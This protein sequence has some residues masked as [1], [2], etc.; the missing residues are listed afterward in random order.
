MSALKKRLAPLEEL[1]RRR[2]GAKADR[3]LARIFLRLLDEDEFLEYLRS[4]WDVRH[5][6]DPE[7][8]RVHVQVERLPE[9]EGECPDDGAA[10]PFS[11]HGAFEEASDGCAQP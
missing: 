8:E 1:R 6:I 11:E 10:E 3:F 7:T 4:T 2:L 5:E 9:R